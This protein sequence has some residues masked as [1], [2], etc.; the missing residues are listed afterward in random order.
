MSHGL[1]TAAP[2]FASYQ[3]ARKCSLCFLDGLRC[4]DMKPSPVKSL[5]E[6]A[7]FFG[8]LEKKRSERKNISR[9]RMEKPGL[10]DPDA[11]IDERRDFAFK[12]PRQAAIGRHVEIAR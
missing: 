8:R 1:V 2:E 9:L 4:A 10:D 6:Q 5:A 7:S 11:G 12:P 3:A